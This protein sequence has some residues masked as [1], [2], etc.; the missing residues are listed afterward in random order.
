MVAD[1]LNVA[2]G[3]VGTACFA[4]MMVP[5][6]LLNY[7]RSSTVGLSLSLVLLWH[8]AAIVYIAYTIA[9]RG[10]AWLLLSM[11]SF[12]TVSA[13]IEA[14]VYAYGR[15]EVARV[16]PLAALL[17][18]GS[19]AGAVLVGEAFR[20]WLPPS[21]QLAIGTLL[22]ALL[23]AVG[24]FPQLASFIATRSIDGYSFTVTAFDVVGSAANSAVILLPHGSDAGAHGADQS[25][26][27][28]AWL[29]C[30]PFLAII[31][32]HIVLLGLAGWIVFV[33]QRAA[34]AKPPPAGGNSESVLL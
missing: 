13:L 8:G 9:T 7:R 2:C 30:A 25:A 31:A 27:A 26:A 32:L 23:F 22:P 29:A 10:S 11:A 24:F 34:S 1:A 20:A 16:G 5:Q 12:S 21:A 15:D 28:S 4:L 19:L 6:A 14:Q 33:P 18:A 3:I 17:A